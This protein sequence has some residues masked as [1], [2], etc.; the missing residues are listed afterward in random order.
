[1]FVKDGD[2]SLSAS[3]QYVEHHTESVSLTR[4]VGD[5]PG[6]LPPVRPAAPPQDD[7]LELSTGGRTRSTRA[8]G[9]EETASELEGEQA[10][11][12]KLRLAKLIIEILTGRRVKVL[13]A[14]DLKV[15][16]R[17]DL[18]DA[19]EQAPEAAQGQPARQGWGL[20]YHEEQTYAERQDLSFT[21]QGV[22]RTKDGQEISFSL[23]LNAS[24]EFVSH[25]SLDVRAGDAVKVDPLVINFDGLA[26]ELTGTTFQFDLDVDGTPEDL[27][28]LKPG[29]GFLTLDKD[30]DGRITSGAELFGPQS[31]DA[32][33]ELAGFDADRN[34]W[35]DEADPVYRQL[36]VWTREA[37]GADSLLSLKQ[38]GIGAI[39]L[40]SVGTRFDL[41]DQGNALVGVTDRLGIYLGE[42]GLARSLQQLDLVG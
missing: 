36:G 14:E 16:D 21:A 1:M 15:L 22:V 25:T 18:A 4:W 37:G 13:T 3:Y 42:D 39:Y 17:E 29:S 28:F 20:E 23:Q 41:K 10:L 27:H 31:G 24:R 6:S 32:L 8:R 38:A 19:R 2:I 34:G 9:L 33:G 12:P 26:A 30:G 11:D 35:I 5:R 7:R 40:G